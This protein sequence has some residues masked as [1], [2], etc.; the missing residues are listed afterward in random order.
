MIDP[1]IVTI[2]LDGVVLALTSS[3]AL[4]LIWHNLNKRHIALLVTLLGLVIAWNLGSII[5]KLAS[6]FALGF[7]IVSVAAVIHDAGFA[8]SS[9]AFYAFASSLTGTRA[10]P[11][12]RAAWL[13]IGAVVVFRLVFSPLVLVETDQTT[14]QFSPLPMLVFFA[15]SVFG[16]YQLFANR[17][18]LTSP[19]ILSGAALF[20]AGQGLAFANPALGIVTISTNLCSGGLLLMTIGVIRREIIRPLAEREQ[21]IAALHSVSKEIA[22]QPQLDVVLG[23]IAVQAANWIGGDAAGIFLREDDQLYLAAIYNLPSTFRGLRMSIDNGVCGQAIRSEKAQLIEN[24]ARDWRFEPDLPLAEQ[25]F[26][27][28]AAVPLTYHGSVAGVLFVVSGHQGRM[29]RSDD[30]FRLEL[31]APQAAIAIAYSALL[32]QQ[33]KLLNQI[34]ANNA[35]LESLLL[36]TE[37]PVIAVDRN[38]TVQFA[39]PAALNLLDVEPDIDLG[40]IKIPARYF[41]PSP[42]AMVR[43]LQLFKV[44]EYEISLD[45]ATFQCH[46]ARLG[47]RRHQGWVAV[48]HDVSRLKELDRMKGEMIRMVSH[49]LKNPL[50]GAMLNVDLLRTREDETLNE[51]LD[52]LDR[53][54]DRMDR[55]I[56][57]VLDLERIRTGRLQRLPHEIYPIASKVIHDLD[58]TRRD[59]NVSISNMID[60]E[61][62]L[63]IDSEQFERALANLVENAIKFSPE[64]SSVTISSEVRETDQQIAI[65]VIDTGIG[66]PA[67][68]QGQVFDRFFR[69]RQRGF[70]HVSGSGL[71]L[72]L[73]KAI[74]ELHGGT[75]ALESV[76]GQ[77]SCFSLVFGAADRSR[78]VI[79]EA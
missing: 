21:Q 1:T 42:R 20:A 10:T 32:D 25:T 3:F 50:M 68:I 44:H 54:L 65:H 71:G 33:R 61:L 64:G 62:V 41:P 14:S 38:L 47:R 22:G 66:I 55:I 59:R 5:I 49:D 40:T 27:S 28:F 78:Q 74:M 70:E 51:S 69:G 52:A 37:N 46:V 15:Y 30:V 16:I 31:L 73:V 29:F 63:D 57:G 19:T 36:S 48:L 9:V 72:A 53:Q 26:G 11:L 24:Y 75:V 58:R 45:S 35:Q 39:N 34:E 67:E 2:V 76:E 77:G 56:R 6:Q 60:P 4:L 23:Q 17:R 12:L 7:T 79:S 43:D 8:A 18:K 13:G